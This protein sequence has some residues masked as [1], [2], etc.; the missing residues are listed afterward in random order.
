MQFDTKQKV[1]LALYIEYQKD[2]PNMRSI[3]AETLEIDH[4]AF[5]VA[6]MKLETEEYITDLIEIKTLGSAPPSYRLDRAK[7]TRDGVEYVETKLS[8]DTRMS[9]TEKVT[10]I[11]KKLGEWGMEQLK[12]V[13]AKVAAELIKGQFESK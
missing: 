8:I 11:L 13:S 5:S 3:N 4:E 10:G 2:V 7:L 6:L 9:G 1:L 12:D